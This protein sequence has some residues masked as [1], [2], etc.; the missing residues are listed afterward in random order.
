M[1]RFPPLSSLK[2]LTTGPIWLVTGVV[3]GGGEEMWGGGAPREQCGSNF[4][5][6]NQL[7]GDGGEAWGWAREAGGG[8]GEMWG[9]GGRQR[10]VFVTLS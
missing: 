1:H 7:A 3:A 8:G 5:P 6:K 2:N 4:P 9:G 10:A